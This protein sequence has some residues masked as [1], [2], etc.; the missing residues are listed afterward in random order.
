VGEDL[1][2][3]AGLYLDEGIRDE[4]YEDASDE[5][6]GCIRFLTSLSRV[7]GL[8]WLDSNLSLRAF[9]VEIGI[10][11]D[12]PNVFRAE[13]SAATRKTRIDLSHFW[14]RHRSMIRYCASNPE[15]VGFVSRRMV[16]SGP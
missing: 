9:G 15:A 13:N 1:D 14:M 11:D 6:K 2:I 3:P 10:N 8:L 4:K 5:L 7:D 12:P 16:T